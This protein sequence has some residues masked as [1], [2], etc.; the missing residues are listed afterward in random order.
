[1]NSYKPPFLFAG[2]AITVLSASPRFARSQQEKNPSKPSPEMQAEMQA[3][4]PGPA[5]EQMLKRVGEYTTINK[6]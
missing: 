3:A 4:M 5:H 2:L 6:L 1:M